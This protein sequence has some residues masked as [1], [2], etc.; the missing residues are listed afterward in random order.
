MGKL[1]VC[2]NAWLLISSKREHQGIIDDQ[3]ALLPNYTETR[4]SGKVATERHAVLGQSVLEEVWKDQDR[5]ELPSFVSPAPKLSQVKRTP[6]A[7]HWRSI[8]TIH[9]VIT[10]IR[11]WGPETGRKRDMLDNFMHLITAIQIASMRSMSP[12]LISR[13]QFHFHKYLEGILKLYPEAKMQPYHHISLHL[14]ILLEAFG[15]V[16]SWRAWA[17]ERYNYMLQNTKTNKKFG[18][19]VLESIHN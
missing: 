18:M 10:L 5:L 13:Y 12:A 7:D 14:G 17:F 1:Q 15:P 2:H 6:S 11:I 3:G 9:L 8:G 19:W 16:H 4:A